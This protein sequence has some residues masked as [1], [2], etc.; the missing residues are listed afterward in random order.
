[1]SGKFLVLL[2]FAKHSGLTIHYRL[3]FSWKKYGVV[4]PG[5]FLYAAGCIAQP[6][7][8]NAG[9]ET[10][11][12]Y[13]NLLKLPARGIV[14]G[15]QDDLAYG[16]HWKYQAGRSD[17]KETT[18]QYPG[19][20]GWELGGIEKDAAVNLDS[21][22]FENMKAYI[23]RG[24]EAGAVITIS[25]H[26]DNPVTG[27]SAWAPSPA[28]S[29]PAILPGGEKN[30]LFNSWLDKVAAFFGDLKTKKG[31]HIPV[32]FRPFHELNGDWFWWGGKNCT[33]GE[34]KELWK[35]TVAYLRDKKGLHQLL[36][37]YNTDRFASES[38]YLEKY[39]G[40]AWVD[41]VGFDIYQKGDI[42]ANDKFSAALDQN[43]S[44]LE[45]IAGS[46]GDIPALTEFGYNEVPGSNWWTSVFLPVLKR[47]SIAY[48]LAW[49]NAGAK[50]DGSTEYYVPYSGQASAVDFFTFSRSNRMLFAK[51][52]KKMALYHP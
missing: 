41:V 43:L 7:D 39:P 45:K 44:M 30:E 5:L 16:V 25:W 23:R 37:A 36:Y 35:Y 3:F 27:K 48:V 1:M 2:L 24:Y 20:Y 34:F 6:V 28:N 33:P 17:V 51:R 14:F 15:H 8:A 46:T 50:G 22:P 49:R 21:V 18:G 52:V 10:K 31:V 9:T 47:H 19:L 42:L 40:T 29:I 13:Y 11:A 26:L 32:I 38:E 4:L 12:L